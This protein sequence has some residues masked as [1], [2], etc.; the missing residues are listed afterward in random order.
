MTAFVVPYGTGTGHY[1]VHTNSTALVHTSSSTIDTVFAN[2]QWTADSRYM[3]TSTTTCGSW[4]SAST[5]T[6]IA[7]FTNVYQFTP[8]A[9]EQ[10]RKRNLLYQRERARKVHRAKGAIKRALKLMD[11]V[12]FGNDIRIFLRGDSIE[13]AHPDSLFKF[14]MHKQSYGGVIDKT[15]NTGIGTPYV[16]DL[17]TKTDVFVASLC[18]YLKDTPILDQILAV[19]MFIKSGDEDIILKQA[20]W[21]RLTDDEDT[22]L[23][24]A[25]NYPEL[26]DKLRLQRFGPRMPSKLEHCCPVS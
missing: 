5:A 24:V 12:G 17:Y 4:S 18:V 25:V 6:S 23:E 22:V 21:F 9:E 26:E 11:S 2:Q 14:V 1:Y 8:E 15:I 10:V 13:I 20:N 19:S 16:L 7:W 3:T